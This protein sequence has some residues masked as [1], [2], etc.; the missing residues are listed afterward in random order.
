MSNMGSRDD[1]KAVGID[2]SE[3]DVPGR[4]KKARSKKAPSKKAPSKEDSVSAGFGRR[5]FLKASGFL[6]AGTA[7]GCTRGPVPEA[8]PLLEGTPEMVPGRSSWYASTCGA[9]TAA[10]GAVVRSRDGRPLK[11]EGNSLHSLSQGGLCAV[12]QASLL[13]LYDS[14]RLLKP[15]WRGEA[16]TW[17]KLDTEIEAALNAA[18][19]SGRSVRLLTETLHS[20]SE[21]AAIARFGE[22]FEDFQHVVYDPL[23][24]SAILDAHAA[25]H[26][27]R[28][29][30]RYRIDAA[31]VL[32]SFD[33]DFLATWIS[34][35]EFTAGYRKAR[36]LSGEPPLMSYHLQIE[37]RL[38]LTG[39][40][41]DERHAIH[42]AE[43]ASW[44]GHLA[45]E[46][47]AHFGEGLAQ[48]KPP[49]G[50]APPPVVAMA[51]RLS[52]AR[53]HSLVL[54][55]S[56]DLST[57]ILCNLINHL[58]GNYGNSLDLEHPSLQRM[59]DDGALAGLRREL[60][61]GQV[62]VLLMRGVNPVYDLPG[63]EELAA[64]IRKVPL[65]VSFAR[66]RD[67]TASASTAIC[68]EPHFLE[69]WRDAEP[70]R[71]KLSLTQP[72][73]RP[74]GETR[75]FARTL[76]TWNGEPKAEL[77]WLREVWKREILPLASASLSP[78]SSS[79][80]VASESMA[81]ESMA[82]ESMAFEKF[83]DGALHDGYVE[84]R[85]PAFEVG[86]FDGS[87]LEL[88]T[89]EAGGGTHRDGLSLILYPKV[90]M[91]DGRHAHNAWLQELPDPVTKVSWDNY[92]SLAPATA[93]ELGVEE[94]DL[95]KISKAG[96]GEDLVLPALLQPGQHGAVVAL[97]QGYGRLGTDRFAQVGPLWLESEP[98]VEAGGTVG[99]RVS[100]WLDPGSGQLTPVVHGVEV[101]AVAGHQRLARSQVYDDREV[102]EKLRPADGHPRPI[103]QQAS[104]AAYTEDRSAGKPHGHFPEADLWQEFPL[105]QHHWG[106]AIDLTACTGCSACVLACQV[107]NNVPVVGRDEVRRRRDL[108]WMRIDRY[109]SQEGENLEVAHQPML[110]H[111]CDNAPCETV[112]PVLATVHSEEG[113]NQQIYNR[114]VGTRY[115]ANNCP[116][117]VRRFNWFKYAHEDATANLV[118]NP[119]VTVRSRGVMEKCS[120]CVQR[121]Q[122]AKISAKARREEL[123]VDAVKTACQQSCPAGAIVFGDLADPQ[124]EIAQAVADPRHYRLFEELNIEPSVG[125]RRLIR[126]RP[127]EEMG[128]ADP[129][130]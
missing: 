22:R 63:G 25:T 2:V 57:Q 114:C 85:R 35:V 100:D 47:G 27:R 60:A 39:S 84:V 105:G 116:F 98:T 127:E 9:C 50:N 55:G 59:G 78:D 8:V 123:A 83:W 124:S 109:Y 92:A 29:L 80:T 119:D 62:E 23:S 48:L 111:H 82:S 18:A 12:G 17:E 38:S 76:L 45:A 16:T 91:L 86:P 44:M 20:P 74:L 101:T 15:W 43:M 115:C 75:G 1:L 77:D 26:G 64:Q 19:A 4:S 71:G 68:P 33:A 102:P 113:L 54:C 42:P 53:G 49:A 110:C 24:T 120:F 58:L 79:S 96:G 52:K 117:K 129:H 14:Q 10:C 99:S 13:E 66:S 94:G 93:A 67:E 103:I 32:V 11:L 46:L 21:L 130:A 28:V 121:I 108:Y 128:H 89:E 69:D 104:L 51:E 90:A 36:D 125:Y 73:I 7:M 112:C 72:L 6:V 41:A 97:A 122:E 106:M 30:P 87:A 5:D 31:D 70:V 34:P 118:L 61:S 126:N 81:S 88:V 37:S 3:G 40:N 107:E 56:Q 65:S 95:V